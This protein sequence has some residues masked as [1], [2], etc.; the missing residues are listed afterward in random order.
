MSAIPLSQ[1]ILHPRATSSTLS[2]P[3]TPVDIPP[4]PLDASKDAGQIVGLVQCP[5]CSHTLREPVTLPCGNTLCKKCV[6]RLHLRANISY[7][8][9][10]NRLQGF[11]CPFSNCRRE[12]AEGDYSVD[13]V[14]CKIMHAVRTEMDTHRNTADESQAL[15]QAQ[16]MGGTVV[17]ALH[18]DPTQIGGASRGRLLATYIMAEEG[19]LT[20]NSEAIC[21]EMECSGETEE[22]DAML[23]ERLK[24][25]TRSELDCQVCYGVFLDPLTANCGHTLCRKCFHRV[26][27]HSNLCPICR[28][29]IE[30][31]PGVS[32]RQSPSNTFLTNWLFGLF[33][34]DLASRIEAARLD[35]LDGVGDLDIPLFVCAISFPHMPTFLHIFE[36]RYRL[37]I[38]RVIETGDRKFGMLLYNPTREAQGEL[39]RVPFYEY[40]TLLNVVNMQLLP[41]GRSLLETVGVSRFRVVKHSMLDGYTVGKIERVSDISITEE[42]AIEATETSS[43][44]KEASQDHIEYS[45]GGTSSGECSEVHPT[46]ELDSLSTQELMNLGTS[47]IKKMQDQSAPW[48]HRSVVN[49]YGDCPTDAALFPWWFAS[50]VPTSD[51]EKYRMLLTSSVRERLKMC[52]GWT[53]ELEAQ[54]WYAPLPP[55]FFPSPA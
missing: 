18:D 40:G 54:R 11:L 7:P 32:A 34:E 8:A 52:V 33:H 1:T 49:A 2:N 55:S 9:T 37:M 45:P 30:I 43:A 5:Q 47:F 44:P 35:D 51:A 50:V 29:R 19:E 3:S 23:L 16:V 27:D 46:P 25:S 4:R 53:K 38:R 12:H 31:P 36:P 26:L 6:P 14:L 22:L 13:V 21:A 48:L 17:P 15:L 39:G 10:S 24:E 42:E 20:Y 28:R 41:D